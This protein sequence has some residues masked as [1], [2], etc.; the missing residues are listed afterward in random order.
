L[1][2]DPIV[3]KMEKFLLHGLDG[4][5]GPFKLNLP[6]TKQFVLN[7]VKNGEKDLRVNELVLKAVNRDRLEF[8]HVEPCIRIRSETHD[9]PRTLQH[10]LS[11]HPYPVS[12]GPLLT[13]DGGAVLRS[14]GEV[15]TKKTVFSHDVD[16]KCSEW[17]PSVLGVACWGEQNETYNVGEVRFSIQGAASKIDMG[18]VFTC[19]KF[20]C[21][22]YCPCRT[23]HRVICSKLIHS[24]AETC[25]QCSRQ[26]TLHAIKLPRLFN[27]DTDQ[28]TMVT[29]KVD[30]YL[31]AIPYAGIPAT[32]V[33]CRQDVLEHQVLHLVPHL[34]CKFCKQ[35]FRP[36]DHQMVLTGTDFKK[37]IRLIKS[38]DDRTCGVCLFMCGSAYARKKH[39]VNHEA[40]EKTFKCEKCQK[41]YSNTNALKYH[42]KV[43]H[44]V[45]SRHPCDY[46]GTEFSSER[47]LFRHKQ[48]IHGE[49][50]VELKYICDLCGS[51]FNRKDTLDRHDKEQ[52]CG[53]KV[54]FAYV[55]HVEDM[56]NLS[57]VEC[58]L[59][60]KTFKRKSDLKRHIF[61]AHSDTATKLSCKL[62]GKT[63]SRQF[64]L[65]RH[66]K[67]VHSE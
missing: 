5:K 56:E 37:S 60:I 12:Q 62:C 23:C 50:P 27:V 31:F 65:N 17:L 67:S 28:F 25:R 66:M 22:I 7:A 20:K 46:C 54:N 40:K 1:I 13:A 29:G 26:C 18:I 57:S 19:Q 14:F 53:S 59:C 63:F 51:K 16:Q 44:E 49:G 36:W 9:V 8:Y 24:K 10:I 33:E 4:E 11:S 38:A 21:V 32:C 58:R 6:F 45:I 61:C 48:V 2:S 64:T 55:E 3:V 52:H 34:H 39:E 42:T 15:V 47:T 41:S 30:Q 43:K 35:E